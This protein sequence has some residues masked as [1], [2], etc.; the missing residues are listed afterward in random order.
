MRNI[1]ASP[2]AGRLPA[3]L[4]RTDE[5]V[6]ALDRRLCADPALGALSGRFLFAV[7]DGS[8]TVGGRG[9]DVT[10]RGRATARSACGSR[11]VRP[12]APSRAMTRRALAVD[13]ARAFLAV[14]EQAGHA[15][16]WRV[17]DVPDGPDLVAER[18]GATVVAA[19]S[20]VA[21]AVVPLGRRRP[22]RRALRRDRPAAA[23]A[24][25]PR[26]CSTPCVALGH[27]DVRA[28]TRRTLSFVD[29]PAD[30]AAPA[31]RRAGGGRPGRLGGL[32][33]VGPD[34]V[35][36]HGRVR[37]RPGRRARQGGGAG[38]RAQPRR[39]ARALVG[40]RARLRA[41][42]RRPGG[43]PR[44][45]LRP[46]RRGD[47]PPLVRHDPRRG[48]PRRARPILERVVVRMIHACGMVDLVDDVAASPGFG[49]AGRAARCARARR[50]SATPRWSP[51]AS[52]ARGCPRATTSS[53]RCATRRSRRSRRELGTTRTAA[54]MELWRER[55]GGA[56]VVVGNAPTALFRLLELVEQGVA[57]PAAVIGVPVGFIGA[58]E[59][60]AAL[61]EHPAGLEHLV[62]HGRRGGSAIAA[63]AVNA[64]GERG[65]MSRP[66]C[67]ASASGPGDPELLTSR[68]QRIIGGGRRDRLPER[69]RTAAASRGAIAAPHLRGDQIEVALDVPGHDR[70]DR[71]P[72]RLRGAR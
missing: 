41:T 34:R 72:R 58:A 9:A 56:V 18:L 2:L 43:Q 31:A 62:V 3:S 4:A 23:G 46:R 38:G 24:A 11:A 45:R 39:A 7:D 44:E 27:D 63:A 12:I 65:G 55:L 71:P 14:A 67:T 10:L 48:R 28:S 26:R 59:S 47:L 13:A 19:A 29:V 36:G 51:R 8:A 66:R 21:P 42:A 54:A 20:G 33:L 53:A 61:A 60:K 30:D 49:A 57:P 32:G 64:L 15:G 25:R 68:P 6:A 37:A 40:L 35:L 52:R 5:V 17:A 69:A 70:A 16:A 50:S 22:G 1:A